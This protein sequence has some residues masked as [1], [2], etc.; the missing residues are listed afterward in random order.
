V[1]WKAWGIGVLVWG[2]V[3]GVPGPAP[4]GTRPLVWATPLGPPGA[5][6]GLAPLGPGALGAGDLSRRGWHP[7]AL[8]LGVWGPGALGLQ[9]RGLGAPLGLGPP[10]GALGS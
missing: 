3:P 6:G 1:S 2:L 10:L 7:G 8:S 5:P 9:P 4:L